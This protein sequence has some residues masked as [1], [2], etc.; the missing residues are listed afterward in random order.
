MNQIAAVAP[1][2]RLYT[3]SQYE[4]SYGTPDLVP[5]SFLAVLMV[6]YMVLSI[7]LVLDRG[8]D[9]LKTNVAMI[10]GIII[11]GVLVFSFYETHSQPPERTGNIID[12]NVALIEKSY[13]IRDIQP[14]T[15]DSRYW[16]E[17]DSIE[18]FAAPD[19]NT[20][21]IR[22]AVTAQSETG[23]GLLHL[24]LQKDPGNL[25]RAYEGTGDTQ[26]LITPAAHADN[27]RQKGQ[28]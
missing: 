2:V 28:S 21:P 23:D 6:A 25:V 13:R 7:Y 24:T 22:M 3:Q 16:P 26:H 5:A 4:R 20:E 19:S 9:P 8:C 27:T 10:L 14:E 1:Y 15:P 11:V 18:R 17:E 12:D